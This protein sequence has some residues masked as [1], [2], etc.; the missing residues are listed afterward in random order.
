MSLWG[1]PTLRI[2]EGSN[3]TS[4]RWRPA[5]SW[6]IVLFIGAFMFG[7]FGLASILG[8]DDF[9]DFFDAPRLDLP[10]LGWTT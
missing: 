2:H 1:A 4:V 9:L 7:G 8:M 5:S 10:P 6:D 3:E